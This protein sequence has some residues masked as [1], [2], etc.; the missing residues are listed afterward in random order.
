MDS[1]TASNLNEFN[2]NIVDPIKM[3]FSYFSTG[4]DKNRNN[5]D[6]TLTMENLGVNYIPT[7]LMLNGVNDS[8]SAIDEEDIINDKNSLLKRLLDYSK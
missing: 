4:E 5:E 7:I 1:S 8:I 6:F 2:R 3:T